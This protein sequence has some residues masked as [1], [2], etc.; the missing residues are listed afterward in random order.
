ML[1]NCM[2]SDLRLTCQNN[3]AIKMGEMAE[4]EK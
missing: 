4:K 1:I 2:A 3:K